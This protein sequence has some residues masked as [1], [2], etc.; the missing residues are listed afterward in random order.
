MPDTGVDIGDSLIS[1]GVVLRYTGQTVTIVTLCCAIGLHWVALQSVAWTTMLFEYSKHAPLRQ[2][3]AQ[4]FDG[5]HPCA[6]CHAV[7]KGKKSEKKSEFQAATAK[8]DLICPART[9]CLVFP[10]TLFAYPASSFAHLDIGNSP[11]VPPPR[12]S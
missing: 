6:L 12:S 10:F 8:I 1:F 7:I 9:I 5:S 3:I 11:P 4:T 2:A